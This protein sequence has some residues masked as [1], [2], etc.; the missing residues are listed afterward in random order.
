[1]I[2]Y[3]QPTT[4]DP[5]PV[6]DVEEAIRI[7]CK[8]RQVVN[9]VADPFRWTRSLQVLAGEGFPVLEFP[10]QPG[11]LA[12]ATSSFYEAVVN[13]ALTHDGHA[14][15]ARH[16]SHAIIKQDPRGV[17]ITKESKKSTRRIDLAMA[18]I[19]AFDRAK[20]LVG[21]RVTFW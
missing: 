14:E 3:W 1:V 2:D 5:V 21:K 20:E 7:A 17:R 6:L 9:V 8:E 16:I 4:Q 11:R 12:P 10:Q 18:A 13:K 19:M 15:L